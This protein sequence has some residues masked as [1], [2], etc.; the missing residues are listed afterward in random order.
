LK[1]EGTRKLK[2]G[3][4]DGLVIAAQAERYWRSTDD[5][6]G[7]STDQL[8]SARSAKELLASMEDGIRRALGP[9]GAEI[10]RTRVSVLGSALS[11][12]PLMEVVLEKDACMREALV[13]ALLPALAKGW[14]REGIDLDAAVASFL[15][16]LAGTFYAE[17]SDGA[18]DH[19][20]W[21]DAA[22]IAMRAVFFGLGPDE[23]L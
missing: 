10:R 13:D 22:L 6:A 9:A 23:A 8:S 12:P 20:A 7:F 19:E 21:V 4:R 18:I 16:L 3:H 14:L 15:A 5:G 11:R 2:F 1:V 17:R